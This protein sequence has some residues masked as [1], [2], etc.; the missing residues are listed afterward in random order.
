MKLGEMLIENCWNMMYARVEIDFPE[1]SIGY[2][3]RDSCTFMF[4]IVGYEMFDSSC[5]ALGL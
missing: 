5:Y 1:S 4:L 3:R 2:L